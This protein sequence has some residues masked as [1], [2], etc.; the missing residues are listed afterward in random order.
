MDKTE[1]EITSQQLF[2]FANLARGIKLQEFIEAI[3]HSDAVGPILD[4]TLWRK[5]HLKTDI[6]K[7]LAQGLQ[8]FVQAIPTE[9]QAKAADMNQTLWEDVT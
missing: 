6:L 8:R 5:A 3:E 9:E 1:F 7:R 2:M 4:P